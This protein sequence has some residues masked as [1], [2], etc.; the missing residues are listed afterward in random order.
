VWSI[1]L[2]VKRAQRDDRA[3][4]DGLTT[5][6]REVEG[7]K[8]DS[9]KTRGWLATESE[10]LEALFWFVQVNQTTHSV[11]RGSA[12]ARGR[13]MERRTFTPSLRMTMGFASTTCEIL[14]VYTVNADELA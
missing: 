7:R 2:W 13:C 10:D 4:D 5:A 6:E 3:G 12:A 8:G 9:C 1:A 11:S 14:L